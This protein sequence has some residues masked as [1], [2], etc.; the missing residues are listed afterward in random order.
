MNK[1]SREVWF[2]PRG[3]YVKAEDWLTKN[4]PTKKTNTLNKT[5]WK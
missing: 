2:K 4:R 1:E 5:L 3:C